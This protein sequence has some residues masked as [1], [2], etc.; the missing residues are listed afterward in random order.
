MVLI[1]ALAITD[2]VKTPSQDVGDKAATMLVELVV[3]L[4]LDTGASRRLSQPAILPAG[5]ARTIPAGETVAAA[6]RWRRL[7]AGVPSA[8]M[9]HLSNAAVFSG[10]SVPFLRHPTLPIA[11]IL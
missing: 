4:T 2:S 7:L 9:Q 5:H 1:R 8:R 11:I 3:E 10:K 6:A